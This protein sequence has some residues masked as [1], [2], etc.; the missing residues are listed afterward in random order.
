M[1]LTGLVAPWHV[2]STQTRARTR[3]P[4]I[5]RWTLNHCATRE[6]P[7]NFL[8]MYNSLVSSVF[9]MLCNHHLS[10]VSKLFHHPRRTRV[11]MSTRSPIPSFPQP[12]TPTNLLS[13]SMDLPILGISYKKNHTI[14]DLYMWLLLCTIMISRFIR[15]VA[16]SSFAFHFMTG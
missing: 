13:V 1:W 16:C 12:L 7:I 9:T 8:K 11:P 6:V 3:V 2:G 4:C 10:L 14:C 5:G 15:I